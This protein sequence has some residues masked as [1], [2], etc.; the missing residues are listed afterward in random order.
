MKKHQSD[1]FSS[2]DKRRII[3][4]GRFILT[5]FLCF[6]PT[7][8][9]G[10]QKEKEKPPIQKKTAKEKVDLDHLVLPP[11]RTK[12]KEALKLYVKTKKDRS[13][14]KA[15]I[16]ASIYAMEHNDFSGAEVLANRA[17]KFKESALGYSLRGRG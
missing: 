9:S 6:S 4:S 7:F 3:Y 8:I 1:L 17:L 13:D 12:I 10:C 14:P 2:L 11:K 15:L 16:E 5:V